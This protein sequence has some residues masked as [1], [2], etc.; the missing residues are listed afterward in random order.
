MIAAPRQ[1]YT[2][3]REMS[4]ETRT[5]RGCG[6]AMEFRLGEYHCTGCGG[7]ESVALHDPRQ[8][9]FA[10][11]QVLAQREAAAFATKTAY[12]TPQAQVDALQSARDY[13]QL[14]REPERYDPTPAIETEKWICI[15]L[16]VLRLVAGAAL[17]IFNGYAADYP[18]WLPIAGLQ[19]GLLFLPF[20][21]P[22]A[23]LKF[24]FAYIYILLAGLNFWVV[25]R[26]LRL[27]AIFGS[28]TPPEW[29]SYIGYTGSLILLAVAGLTMLWIAALLFREAHRL[30]VLRMKA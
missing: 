5:C 3:A 8:R 18:V 27:E 20:F 15:G 6:E 30:Q 26:T 9:E 21:T 24:G 1:S 7:R 12:A 11:P 29:Y 28:F 4:A 2:F 14:N 23:W 25:Y 16:F 17:G 22:S 10:P 13:R 19:L